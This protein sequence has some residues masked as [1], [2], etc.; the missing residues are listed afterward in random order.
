MADKPR[1]TIEIWVLV[2]A[3]GDCGAGTDPDEL[4]EHF[5]KE[6]SDLKNYQGFRLYKLNLSVPLPGPIE[7]AAHAPDEVHE[8]ITITLT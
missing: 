1:K 3:D 6:I 8:P 2:T 7:L 4:T 5:E